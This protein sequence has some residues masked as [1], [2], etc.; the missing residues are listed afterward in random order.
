MTTL[1]WF[2]NDLRVAD[3]PALAAARARGRVA[4]IYL[5]SLEQW[6]E[7]GIS[8]LRL[9]Y[10][11]RSLNDLAR[12]LADL[13]ISLEFARA[14]RFA[15]APAVIT[16]HAQRIGAERVHFN[17]EYP[18]DEQRRDTAVQAALSDVGIPGIAHHADTVQPP[19]SILTS[20]G[21]PYAKF[22]PFRNRWLQQVE[23]AS[24]LP[25][26]VPEVQA[27]PLKPYQLPD[28]GDIKLTTGQQWWPTGEEAGKLRL[29]SFLDLRA[30]TYSTDRDFPAKR[31]TSRLSPYLALGVLSSRQCL[32]AAAVA[33]GDRLKGGPLD[34]WISELIWREFYRHVV[35]AFPHVSRGKAFRPETDRLDWRHAPSELESWKAGETGY[36]LVDAGMRQLLETGWMHNRLRMVTAMF[37]SKHLLIDWRLGEKFFMDHLIDAD[38][39][40]NNGG[41]QWSASTGTDAVPY[42]RIFNPHEQARRFDPHQS[43]IHRY[44]PELG[45]GDSTR[46]YPQPIVD[47][48]FARQRALSHFS[49]R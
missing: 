31:G 5:I 49:G 22:S 39:A 36:P 47:H 29:S 41:W 26:G 25:L 27:A 17:I 40:S 6:R 30:D 21:K 8:D 4:A 23:P 12:S 13:G 14:P 11:G 9:A 16:L 28:I 46:D 43:F 1:V 37:L 19:G 44:I 48:R 32:H 34:G 2:R 15:D 20:Q 38:F 42:F 35:Q 10:M 18:F 45:M 33:N 7:H 3:N 24:L